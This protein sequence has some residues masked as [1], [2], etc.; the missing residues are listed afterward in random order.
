[1]GRGVQLA[2]PAECQRLR[3]AGLLAPSHDLQD[4]RNC[5]V[6]GAGCRAYRGW[7]RRVMLCCLERGCRESGEG[8]LYV[9]QLYMS[10]FLKIGLDID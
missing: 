9:Q 4:Y 10:F 6:G 1:M 2:V 8:S 5:G 3:V 7:D